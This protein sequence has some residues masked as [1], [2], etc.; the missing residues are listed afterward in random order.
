MK[1][2]KQQIANSIPEKTKEEL[3]DLA[4]IEEA[5]KLHYVDWILID[6]SKAH[7]KLASDKLISIRATLYHQEEASTG[8]L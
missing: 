3:E 7:S 5:E 6:S 2:I 1:S 8:N 4:L